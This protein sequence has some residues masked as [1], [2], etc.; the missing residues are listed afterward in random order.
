M[1]HEYDV[2]TFA[3]V[4]LYIRAHT[5][6]KKALHWVSD[7]LCIFTHSVLQNKQTHHMADQ[8]YIVDSITRGFGTGYHTY[9]LEWAGKKFG[10]LF[11]QSTHTNTAP[12]HSN[13]LLTYE[14]RIINDMGKLISELQVRLRRFDSDSFFERAQSSSACA[15]R[16]MCVFC[17]HSLRSA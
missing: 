9:K 2:L 5:D 14:R 16:S 13:S 4:F 1:Y 10:A 3:Q 11:Q 6:R 12:H 17:V 8:F 7:R 15:A